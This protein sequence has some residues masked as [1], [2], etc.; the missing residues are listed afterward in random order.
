ME[1]RNKRKQGT[2]GETQ[3]AEYL[4][5]LGFRIVRRNYRYGRGEIDLIAEEHGELIFVEVK[6]RRSRL[7]GTPE[8]AITPQKQKKIR[9]A[10]EG[11][12]A[13]YQLFDRICRFDVIAIECLSGRTEIR[14]IRDA[15]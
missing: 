9:A 14:H 7:Y 10:A 12:L 4:K 13:Q 15:F 5:S 2:D 1:E 6:M 3:A 11:Y 8:E